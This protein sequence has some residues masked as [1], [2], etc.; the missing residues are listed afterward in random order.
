MTEFTH[1][2]DLAHRRKSSNVGGPITAKMI[3]EINQDV[4]TKKDDPTR[5]GTLHSDLGTTHRKTVDRDGSD[6]EG[7]D[8]GQPMREVQIEIKRWHYNVSHF[9]GTEHE[10]EEQL[11]MYARQGCEIVSVQFIEE[12]PD[13]SVPMGR[14]LVV[15][16]IPTEREPE[17]GHGD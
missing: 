6:E 14:Y 3:R 11:N 4:L 8:I 7:E 15:E 10:L 17:D 12:I 2:D 1:N 5:P 13:T 9:L 16:K